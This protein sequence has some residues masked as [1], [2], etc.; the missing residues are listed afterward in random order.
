MQYQFGA[1]TLDVDRRELTRGAEPVS[2]G[3]QVFDLLTH[4]LENRERVVSKDDLMQAVWHGRIVSESTLT[5]HINAARK[6]IG[7]RGEQQDLIRTFSRK[8]YRFVG[9]VAERQ[10]S[11][12]MLSPAAI[13]SE[14]TT[15]ISA[16]ALPNKPSIA[17]LPFQNLSGDPEQEYFADGTVED[18]IAAL[19]R[20]R[21]LFVIARNSSFTYKGR[22][23]D[24]KQVS[25][26]LG[27]RYV[28]EGSARKASN[29]VRIGAE[30]IDAT[31]GGTLWADRFEGTMKDIFDLQDQVTASVIRAIAPRLERAEIARAKRKPTESLDA[32]DYFLRGMAHFYQQT[33]TAINEALQLF[34]KAVDLDP[35]FASAYGMAAWCYVWRRTDGLTVNRKQEIVEAARFARRAVELGVDDPVALCRGGHALAYLMHELDVG[36]GYIDRALMLNPN[37]AAAW[38]MSGWIRLFLGELDI[39]IDHQARAMRLSPLDPQTYRMQSGTAFAHFLAG[40]YDDALSWA[41]VALREHPKALPAW[42]VT[43]ASNA[44]AGQRNRAQQAMAHLREI[45]PTLRISNL[46]EWTPFRRPKDLAKFADGLRR[47]GLP[48]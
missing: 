26:D 35:D 33:G 18:I 1:Y 32:Y 8:G 42:G 12:A 28:L 15:R 13:E 45:D 38:Y 3:P 37:L 22:S 16:L 31:T 47:A 44:L 24:I 11:A 5:S 2:I 20:M 6:A 29:R 39:A 14:E 48:D 4:L 10:R 36:A 46:K 21:W 17:V 7:D 40:R 25:R 19:S 23:V 9:E 41:E 30:L 34:S 43:A 27:V